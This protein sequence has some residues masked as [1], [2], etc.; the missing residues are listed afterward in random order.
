MLVTFIIFSEMT[1][2]FSLL[3]NPKP[4]GNTLTYGSRSTT[5]VYIH[6]LAHVVDLLQTSFQD[7]FVARTATNGNYEVTILIME[8]KAN[9]VARHGCGKLEGF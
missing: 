8:R 1:L 5:A 6:T 7:G 4:I 9:D 3:I 2:T